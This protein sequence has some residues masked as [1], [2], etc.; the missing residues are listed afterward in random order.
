MSHTTSK[1]THQRRREN[2]RAR[3]RSRLRVENL[4]ARRLLAVVAADGF[5]S[6]NFSG[7]SEQWD[8][9]SWV[10]SGDATVRS[11]TSPASGSQHARL[12]RSTGDLQRAVD[13][14]DLTDVRLQFSTKL[15]SFEGSDRADVMV[16]GDGTNWTSLQSF[17]NDDDDS[18]YHTYDLAVPD[19]GDTLHIRFDAG[20][21]GSGDYW[22][23]DDVQVTGTLAANQ[24]PV[25]DA[26]V[27]Q[28][29]SDAGG[30]G[31]EFVT[32]TGAGSDSDGT[33]ASY[34]WKEGTTILGTTANISPT[35]AVGT[36][37]LTL[38]VT[39]NEGAS[40]SDTV[41]I[42]INED[43][44]KPVKVFILAGQSNMTGTA[45]VANL[46]PSWNV[47]QDDVWIWLDHNMD[48]GQW[49]TVG[50]GHGLSTHAP[51]PDEPEGL[52][53]ANRL[54]PE[55]SLSRMLADAYPDHRIALIKHVPEDA[56]LP[57]TSTP[58]TSVRPDR[59]TTCGAA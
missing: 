36:H 59:S 38:T 58:K 45:E 54:G 27:D 11:D 55:L 48:G 6:G 46:D 25:A 22:Y 7:G 40:A 10:A 34:E 44:A 12:R 17:L 30:N 16:S 26:G 52:D 47:P 9:G 28:I 33:V 35:L 4:E 42:T 39:D 43:L 53:P 32:L 13:V 21:S 41:V 57:L 8:S 1:R 19:V 15:V 37:T 5:E 20:M 49:T 51:R 24:A 29:L 31:D 50:P 14:T 56:M 3:R 23:I 2:L 18:Q